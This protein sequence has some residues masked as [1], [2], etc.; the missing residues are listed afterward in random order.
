AARAAL[1]ESLT[2]DHVAAE[3]AYMGAA[4]REGFERPYGLAWLLQLAA[5]LGE[6]R[7][8]DAARWR[9]S[10]APLEALAAERLGEWLTRLP[11]AVRIGTHQQ[12]AFALGLALDWARVMGRRELET[13]FAERARALF[14]GDEAAPV[15]YE[16]SGHDFLSPILGEADLMRRVI[17]RDGF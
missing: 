8:A 3:V 4:G 12:R 7:D 16:P 10:L 13:L 15:A 1:A 11:W 14:D 5:E 2:H 17:A 6:W 9:D